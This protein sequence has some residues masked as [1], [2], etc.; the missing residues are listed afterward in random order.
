METL[1]VESLDTKYTLRPTNDKVVVRRAEKKMTPSGLTLP[2]NMKGD[3][4]L[5]GEVVATGPGGLI[6]GTSDR[7]PLQVKA[8]DKI[9]F[10]RH[11]GTEIEINGEKLLVMYENDVLVV[12]ASCSS[13]SSKG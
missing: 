13:K 12:L 11:S 8:G 10:N 7:C 5:E 4:V 2:D 9:L 1:A 3:K 6:H